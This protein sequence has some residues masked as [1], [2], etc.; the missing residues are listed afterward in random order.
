MTEM[1]TPLRYGAT[2]DRIAQSNSPRQCPL[3]AQS[4]HDERE[5]GKDGGFSEVELHDSIPSPRLLPCSE[6]STR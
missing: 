5:R 3:S 6:R 2:G 4:W 1:R